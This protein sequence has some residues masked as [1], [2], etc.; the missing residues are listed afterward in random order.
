MSY[1]FR[2][3]EQ[4]GLKSDLCVL[5]IACSRHDLAVSL[6]GSIRFVLRDNIQANRNR[7]LHSR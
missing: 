5:A 7:H 3:E 2:R 1:L 4:T 6:P